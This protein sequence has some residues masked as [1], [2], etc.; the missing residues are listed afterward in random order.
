M[1]CMPLRNPTGAIIGVLQLLNKRQGRFQKGDESFIDALSVHAAIAIENARL[2]E[3][4]RGL[5]RMQEE[6]RLAARIQSDLLPTAAPALPGYRLAGRTIPARSIGGDYFD[7][8]PADGGRL[9]VV[10][11]DVSGK[12]LPASLLMANLQATLRGQ[13]MVGGSAA[14]T[15]RRANTL[16]HRSTSPEKFATVC[17][18]LLDPA[19]HTITIANAGHE[20]PY[21]LGTDGSVRRPPAGGPPL[22][23][24]EE[25]G[26]PE[27]TLDVPPGALLV[28][29]TD[30]VTEAM[31][32]RQEQYGDVRLER[33]LRGCGGES[34]DRVVDLML[35]DIAA[36]VQ[37]APQHDDITIVVLR[38]V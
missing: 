20:C 3:A 28:L 17:Y 23:I 25:F 13:T 6:V 5:V 9:A 8:I 1:L 11:G 21:L 32:A 38:R 26:F 22:S 15:L 30:G 35:E 16:L 19:V 27:E 37:G 34:P 29:T 18:V 33:L 7:F 2:H 31:N 12:G 14:L 36:H 4:E 10:I 24:L